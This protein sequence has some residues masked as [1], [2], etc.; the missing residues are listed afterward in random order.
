MIE[1]CSKPNFIT[2]KT[3]AGRQATE[4]RFRDRVVERSRERSV[5]R[6]REGVF[7]MEYLYVSSE[8][9]SFANRFSSSSYVNPPSFPSTTFCFQ[10]YLL[11]KKKEFSIFPVF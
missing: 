11:R 3:P 1:L 4:G 7:W 9:N 5:E 10:P 8:T 2:S 6:S